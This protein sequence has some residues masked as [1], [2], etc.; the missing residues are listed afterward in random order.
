MREIE[1][2]KELPVISMNY[3]EVKASLID[4]MKKYEGLV[5]TEE[6]LKDCK[7]TQKEL[8]G[9]R[10]KID[11]YRKDVKRVME[12]PIK[13]FEAKCK[14]LISL[15]E[16]A[17]NPIKQGIGVFDDKRRNNNRFIAEKLREA[18]INDYELSNEYAKELTIL[19]EYTKLTAK[20]SEVKK[21]LEQRALLLKQ[22]EFEM[23]EKT[24][25]IYSVLESANKTIKRQLHFSDFAIYINALS[26]D[27]IITKINDTAK[28]IYEAENP[29]PELVEVNPFVE[30]KHK[31]VKMCFVEFRI[32]ADKEDI[33][34][35][36]KLLKENGF[37]YK[38]LNTG[39]IK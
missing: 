24:K 39:Y 10:N 5:V 1:V 29:T 21:D 3:D 7:A 34:R 17:E 22:K 35:L 33:A 18:V 4:T 14:D 20:P 37:S 28:F 13:D 36:S 11:S 8:A 12:K 30:E 27:Q 31:S 9:L 25:A 15:V 16:E 32:E 38:T 6:S 19:D 26:L 2:I 23:E